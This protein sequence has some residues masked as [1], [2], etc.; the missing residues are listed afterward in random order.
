MASVV[1]AIA[2]DDQVRQ[3][4]AS[5]PVGRANPGYGEPGTTTNCGQVAVTVD[6]LLADLVAGREV[7]P[8]SAVRNRHWS[9]VLL[10]GMFTE[11][12]R[13]APLQLRATR[14]TAARHEMS[15][16]L[17]ERGSRALLWAVPAHGRGHV[18][19]AVNIA[20]VVH[21]L[22]AQNGQPAEFS[23]SATFF[24]MRTDRSVPRRVPYFFREDG[25]LDP[26]WKQIP[27]LARYQDYWRISLLLAP[28]VCRAVPLMERL[29]LHAQTTSRRGME[30][31]IVHAAIPLQRSLAS[32][33]HTAPRPTAGHAA[34]R[35]IMGG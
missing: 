20:G 26:Y 23:E 18:I 34:P 16:V 14:W 22:D 30:A 29:M 28:S 21:F 8:V 10:G 11:M 5:T 31:A 33:L 15:A 6:A 17:A 9:T 7:H 3:L 32:R 27:V 2:T 13:T 24:S 35:H 19:N 4:L 25:T 1:A 12:Y